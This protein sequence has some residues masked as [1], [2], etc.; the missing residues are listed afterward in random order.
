VLTDMQADR[1]VRAHLKDSR[2]NMAMFPH[3]H[4]L[5]FHGEFDNVSGL[6]EIMEPKRI[7]SAGEIMEIMLREETDR[8]R[9]REVD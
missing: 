2:S 6:S 1:V 3:D 9:D 7:A 8:R 4:I 5:Y